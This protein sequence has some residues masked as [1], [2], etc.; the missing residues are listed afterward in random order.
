MYEE[1]R[2]GMKG[3]TGGREDGEC[4][5]TW[6]EE[7]DG[8]CGLWF[9]SRRLLLA[10]QHAAGGEDDDASSKGE[11]EDGRGRGPGEHQ[12]QVTP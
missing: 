1:Q 12:Y 6:A 10:G 11:R 3:V 9:A 5:G 7:A 2:R 8:G 4:G